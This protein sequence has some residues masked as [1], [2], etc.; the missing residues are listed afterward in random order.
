[1]N[2]G[3][4]TRNP[5][6]WS[7]SKLISAFHKLGHNVLKFKFNHITAYIGSNEIKLMVN[8]INILESLSAIVVRPF[9][10]MSLDQAIFRIDL[11]YVMQDKG[12][13]V[14]NKPSAI[15]KC[16]DKFRSLYLLKLHNLPVPRTIVTERSSLALKHIEMLNGND[17]VIKPMFGSRG[18]GSMKIRIR[19]HDILWEVT[20]SIAFTKHTIYLQEYIPHEGVDVRVFVVGDKILAAMHRYAP[21]KQWKTNIARGGKPVKINKLDPYVEEIVLKAAKILECDIAGIDVIL[22][23]DSVYIL[24]VNSQ[25]GWKGLQEVHPDID[26]A[27][28]IA[29]YVISKVKK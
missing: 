19:D 7:S 23:R 20:R 25:P 24:E 14:F 9:G 17:V 3:I 1:M 10:R 22:L 8:N 15:E 13:F 28:E 21:P 27:E 5:S 6:S 16:V 29:K 12:L 18:H 4:I 11:L 26:I 2:I